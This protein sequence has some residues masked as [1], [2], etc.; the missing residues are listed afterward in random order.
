VPFIYQNFLHVTQWTEPLI[1]IEH[2]CAAGIL[3]QFANNSGKA[4]LLDVM[5]RGH[6][7]RNSAPKNPRQKQVIRP[8]SRNRSFDALLFGGNYKSDLFRKLL[9]LAECTCL[10]TTPA[11]RERQQKARKNQ[12]VSSELAVDAVT[13]TFRWLWSLGLSLDRP[14]RKRPSSAAR[15]LLRLIEQKPE[16]LEALQTAAT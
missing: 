13:A 8:P 5:C 1:Q 7:R 2:L 16:L 10:I 14:S 11:D 6:P 3:F 15:T 12:F 9:Q 4:Q